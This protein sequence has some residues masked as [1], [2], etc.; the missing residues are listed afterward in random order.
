MIL[1][2]SP[3]ILVKFHRDRSNRSGD[4]ALYWWYIKYGGRPPSW[5]HWM[6]IWDHPSFCKIRINRYSIGLVSITRKCQYFMPLTWKCLF[7]PEKELFGTVPPKCGVISSP[8]APG[9]QI[10]KL[11]GLVVALALRL[12]RS[13]V[14]LPAIPLSGNNLG[15]AVHTHVSLSPSSMMC[16]L[17]CL[18]TAT[19]GTIVPAKKRP[20]AGKVTVGL[21]LH[22][23]CVKDVNG[24]ST[25]T[26]S[27]A[28]EGRWTRH[29]HSS[30]SMA[31]LIFTRK[32]HLHLDRN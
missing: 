4:M 24:L 9:T 11:G 27:R 19:H 13:G 10:T 22:W 21:A 20:A 16:K 31:H 18:A 32:R 29:L 15:Q 3:R 26:S 2:A 14:W 17:Y 8:L 23:P 6:L 5:I 25:Y 28:K 12:K 30:L 7:T 1:R